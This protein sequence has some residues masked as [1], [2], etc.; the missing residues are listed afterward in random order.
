MAC[1]TYNPRNNSVSNVE[2]LRRTL[3]IYSFNYENI[4]LPRD[5]DAEMTDPSLKKFCKLYSLKNV[6][7]IPTWFKNPDNPKVIDLLLTN[8]TRSFCNSDTLETGLSY[9]HR[10]TLSVLKAYFRKKLK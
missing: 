8:K 4:F 6:K 10:L 5:L 1:C 9:F 3:D 7:K 2:G